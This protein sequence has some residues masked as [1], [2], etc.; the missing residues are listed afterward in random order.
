M[1]LN[2]KPTTTVLAVG[3]RDA[4]WKRHTWSK[5]ESKVV[6]KTD[7]VECVTVGLLITFLGY[8]VF[9]FTKL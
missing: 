4:L 1:I 6:N 5:K 7:I 3:W 2:Y 8:D 9:N